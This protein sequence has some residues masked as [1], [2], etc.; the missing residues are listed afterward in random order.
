MRWRSASL[1][2]SS[3][4]ILAAACGGNGRHAAPVPRPPHIP[5]DVAARL[6]ADADRVASTPDCERRAAAIAL[7]RDVIAAISR[8]P[9]RYQEPLTSAANE[10]VERI[11]PCPRPVGE[12]NDEDERGHKGHGKHKHRKGHR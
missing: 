8:V 3:C 12:K 4:A 1:T 10:L 9:A 2:A 6:A 11:P 5:V 7:R